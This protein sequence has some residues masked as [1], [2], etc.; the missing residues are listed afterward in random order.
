R[1]EWAMARLPGL[2][3]PLLAV[4][5]MQPEQMGWATHPDDVSPHM[6]PG[7]HLVAYEDVGHFVHIEQPQRIADLVLDFLGTPGARP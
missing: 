6:P 3:V 1:P 7:G 2:G 5:G 4:L